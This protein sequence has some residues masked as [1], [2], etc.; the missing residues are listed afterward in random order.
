MA[1]ARRVSHGGGAL[2]RPFQTL[3]RAYYNA[4]WDFDEPN[5]RA[6]IASFVAENPAECLAEAH[7]EAARTREAYTDERQLK[8]YLEGVGLL[9]YSPEDESM[10][11]REWLELVI[12]ATE[13][14]ARS[15]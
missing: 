1:R 12:L 8:G 7:H 6:I 4:D 11:Y 14:G 5:G 3:C 15:A 10:T 2:S 13:A 9:F